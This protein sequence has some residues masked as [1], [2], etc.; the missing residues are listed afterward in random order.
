MKMAVRP[1]VLPENFSGGRSFM[2]WLD[3]FETVA[4]MNA[5]DSEAKA[6][7]L[8]VRL[9][10]CAQNAIKT[11]SEKVNADYTKPRTD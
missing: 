5:W 8:R 6:L 2:D 1:A 4:E 11:P 9:V 7:W 10:G 3:H